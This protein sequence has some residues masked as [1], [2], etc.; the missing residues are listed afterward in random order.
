MSTARI[1]FAALVC[2]CSSVPSSAPRP[3]SVAPSR[4]AAGQSTASVPATVARGLYDVRVADPQGRTGTVTGGL[5]LVTPAE[6]VA[7]FMFDPLDAQ[8]ADVPFVIGLTAV[9]EVGTRVEGFDGTATVT[10]PGGAP[11]LVGPFALGRARGFVT[12]SMP[13][14]Q[15]SLSAADALGH[16]GVSDAFDVT[17]GEAARVAFVAAPERMAAGACGGPFTLEVQDTF[18]NP[19]TAT[20]ASRFTVTVNPPEGGELFADPACGTAAAS[21]ML[22]GRA[23]LYVRATRAGRPQLRVVPEAWPSA[24]REVDVDAGVAVGLEIV[25]APQ[26]LAAGMCS[27][28]VVV[29]ARD[30]FGNAAAVEGGAVLTVE[31]APSTG[32]TLH[33]EGTCATAL[34][35]LE[36]ADG[37]VEARFFFR[38]AVPAMLELG[39]DGGSLGVAVQNEEVTP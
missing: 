18:G 21:G 15:V 38:S 8:R 9:D 27:Q 34:N 17:A 29:R 26:V 14:S 37:G 12:V 13:A 33:D 35:A 16:T 20:A 6:S 4:A 10:A 3:E 25:S 2:A 36:L 31:V 1:A 28:P 24:L 19:A 23:D 39:V 7:A 30:A 5:R 11:V 22:Q 32:V